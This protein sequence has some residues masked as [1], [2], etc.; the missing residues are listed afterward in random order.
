[1]R[2]LWVGLLAVAISLTC[3]AANVL[4]VG[5]H[6]DIGID[7]A[8]TETGEVPIKITRGEASAQEAVP[9][10]LVPEN[11]APAGGVRIKTVFVPSKTENIPPENLP[12]NLP[13][14]N[15]P[16]E[17]VPET[18]QENV[19]LGMEIRDGYWVSTAKPTLHS[20]Q[21]TPPAGLENL[22][23]A[24]TVSAE[25]ASKRENLRSAE[26]AE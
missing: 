7:T 20:A 25:Q 4:C 22:R 14:E 12:E 15:V 2:R 17:N 23:M 19:P 10:R 1:M 21:D 11:E 13:P 16:P 5:G 24:E 26:N 8:R 3:V 9:I 6:P 18:P